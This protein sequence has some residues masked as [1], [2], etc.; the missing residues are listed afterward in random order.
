[1]IYLT[2][3]YKEQYTIEVLKFKNNNKLFSTL[4]LPHRNNKKKLYSRE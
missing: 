2:I 3:S 4:E 1:M